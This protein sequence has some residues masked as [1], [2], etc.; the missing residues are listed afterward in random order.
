MHIYQKSR[1]NILRSAFLVL[2]SAITIFPQNKDLQDEIKNKLKDIPFEFR[3][4]S[5][6]VFPDKSFNIKDFGAVGN[7]E[8]LNSPAINK[9]IEECNKNGGGMVVV[10]AGLW[11]TGPIKMMSN[12]NLHLD[13]GAV[14]LISKDHSVYNMISP[15]GGAFVCE[16][17]IS[18]QNLNN[19]AIT[20]VGIFDGSGDS[21]R[22]VKKSKMTE[23]QWKELISSGGI[24]DQSTN[25]WWPSLQAMNGE[26][27]LA[28]KDK[29]EMDK[30]DYEN[31]KDFLRPNM[32]QFNNC[33][34]V[35]LD[36][37]TLKNSPKFHLYANRCKDL[38]IR[39]VKVD[40]DWWAQNGD[41]LDI[42]ACKNVLLYNCTVNAGD[43]GICMKSSTVKGE[44]FALENIVIMDCVVYHAHG[45][46]VIGSNTDGGMKNI[47]VKN[48]S[49]IGTDIGLRFKSNIG[50]GGVVKDIFIEDIFM[51]DIKEEAIIFDMSYEDKAVGKTQKQKTENSKVPDF[52]NFIMKNIF[53]A[54]AGR[55]IFIDGKKDVSIKNIRLQNSIINAKYGVDAKYAEGFIFENTKINPVKGP[56]YLLDECANFTIKKAGFNKTENPFIKVNGTSS[57]NIIIEETDL[58]K[59]TIPIDIS[60]GADK[61]AVIIK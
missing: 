13:A 31:V 40:T 25:I 12:V 53:C 2:V 19:I 26:V 61:K 3:E 48:C 6:P 18:G 23:S 49:F 37:F 55:A 17:P 4:L 5:I 59:F 15:T 21:W 33:S 41:G 47:F 34:S 24:V 39:N 52:S 36:G 22:P 10:P 1:I 54:S 14:V 50:R 32:M 38:V 9:A 56:V 51:N 43:D 45:G 27:Y 29:K 46:F 8:F 11:H 42:S 30:S 20:G 44:S 58:S 28:S 7:G 57:T 35:F 16:S 60:E